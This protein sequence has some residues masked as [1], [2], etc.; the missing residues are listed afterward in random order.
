M[1]LLKI[2]EHRDLK[3]EAKRQ[4]RDRRLN[5][6][7]APQQFVNDLVKGPNPSRGK[8]KRVEVKAPANVKGSKKVSEKVAKKLQNRADSGGVEGEIAAKM[9]QK[10]GTQLTAKQQ[11]RSRF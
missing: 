2:L 3:D 5:A 7:K 4:E 6:G 11:D 1:I 10:R 9:L 8:S